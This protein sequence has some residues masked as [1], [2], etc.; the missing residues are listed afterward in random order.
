MPRSV[1]AA[2]I[3]VALVVSLALGAFA[4]GR[5]GEPHIPGGF[6]DEV[7]VAGLVLPTDMAFLPDGGVLVA[8]KSGIVEAGRRS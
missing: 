3:A 7:L 6:S 1:I 5:S 4:W 2:G 8:E